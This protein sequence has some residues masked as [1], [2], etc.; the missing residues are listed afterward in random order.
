MQAITCVHDN[1]P[2]PVLPET[3]V[4]FDDPVAFHSPNRVFNPDSDGG[5]TTI[6]RVLRGREFSSR[7]FF[8]GL[9]NGDV[10]QP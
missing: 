1:V 9:D 3:D 4:V 2:N 5:H 6:R 10:M 7:R 8:L